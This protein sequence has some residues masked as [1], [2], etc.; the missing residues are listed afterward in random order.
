MN[1]LCRI[2]NNVF[3]YS[4]FEEA[5]HNHPLFLYGLC[6]VTFFPKSTVWK[7]GKRVTLHGRKLMNIT[8]VRCSRLMSTVI[9][10]VDSMYV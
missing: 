1:L 7:E 2:P 10:H 9:S 3:R 4:A 8:P 5:E 6:M